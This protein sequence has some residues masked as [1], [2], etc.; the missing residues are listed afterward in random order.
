MPNTLLKVSDFLFHLICTFSFN[1]TQI[2]A[3]SFIYSKLFP[4]ILNR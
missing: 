1:R 4:H 2:R 3:T